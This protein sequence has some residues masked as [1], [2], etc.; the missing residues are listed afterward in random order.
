MRE[1]PTSIEIL[2]LQEWRTE[3]RH[4]R[5]NSAVLGCGEGDLL[6][7]LK[8]HKQDGDLIFLVSGGPVGLLERIAQEI[9]ADYAVGTRHEVINGRYTGRPVLPACQ[10]PNK[11]ALAKALI[12]EKG[13][14]IDLEASYA[15]ADSGGD[16]PLLEMVGHPI[17]VYPDEGLKPVAVER[18][19]KILPET[20]NK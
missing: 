18:G 13:L 5:C 12:A 14:E 7:F 10:G 17:A 6:Y 4:Y 3:R 19:W 16:I 20:E 11:P 15:Y 8:K 1:F 9:G 2:K